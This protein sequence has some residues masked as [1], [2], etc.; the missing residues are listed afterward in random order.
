MTTHRASDI[1]TSSPERAGT[2]PDLLALLVT[3]AAWLGSFP[4]MAQPGL[5]LELTGVWLCAHAIVLAAY[6]VHEAAH[7]SLFASPR[8]N[9]WVGEVMNFVAGTP[10][11]SFERIRHMH[12]RHHVERADLTCFD[13]KELIRRHPM[14][15]KVLEALEWA[16]LPGVEVLMRLQLICR[17][18]WVPSQRR[19][20]PRAAG[21]LLLRAGLLVL[22]GLYSVKAV[23]LYGVAVLLQMRV[24]NFFDAFH[25][26]FEQ[27]RVLPE[28]PIP[29]NGRTRAYEQANTYSNLVSTRAPWL[30]LLVLNFV[31]HNAHHHRPSMPWWRLPAVHRSLY[32][33]HNTPALLTA[34]NLIATWHRNRVRRV[35]ADDYGTVG[36]GLRRGD[37]FIGAHGASFLT[38]V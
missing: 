17:P 15:R 16:Y 9:H 5:L 29:L 11:A 2:V 32:G 38:V 35:F 33:D 10:Y 8:A 31:Y 24:L 34:R 25:H 26:T 36:E 4:L 3:V 23:L 7:Q 27:Y 13:P 12:I 37:T 18:V 6:L 14:L 21:M 28:E 22:L 19:Y 1:G 20:L 30:N